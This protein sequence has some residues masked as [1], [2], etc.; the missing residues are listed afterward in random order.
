MESILDWKEIKIIEI[1][2]WEL[3]DVKRIEHAGCWRRSY[4]ELHIQF[5]CISQRNANRVRQEEIRSN[6]LVS[7][8]NTKQFHKNTTELESGQAHGGV[9]PKTKTRLAGTRWERG[10]GS[11]VLELSVRWYTVVYIPDVYIECL[12][13]VS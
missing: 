10:L 5:L 6:T 12:P 9:A 8:I 2:E 4:R 13:R 3:S 7:R 1:Q 11:E